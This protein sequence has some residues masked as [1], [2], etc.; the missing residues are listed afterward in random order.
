M[1]LVAVGAFGCGVSVSMHVGRE[2][3]GIAC[4]RL[5]D[6]LLDVLESL[7]GLIKQERHDGDVC[8]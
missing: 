5:P 4:H 7:L 2:H 6:R 8:L 1:V 3:I